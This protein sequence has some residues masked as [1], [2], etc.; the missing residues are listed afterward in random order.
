MMLRM[1]KG[2]HCLVRTR[3]AGWLIREVFAHMS[4]AVPVKRI[5]ETP[6]LIAFHHPNPGYP[7]HILLVP[8]R[9]YPSLLDLPVQDSEFMCDLIQTVQLLVRELGLEQVGYRLVVNGGPNQD[10]PVL[11]FHLISGLPLVK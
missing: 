7:V 5:K 1:Q 10:V 11:H 9:D 8:K 3:L 6:S 4:Y 2:L